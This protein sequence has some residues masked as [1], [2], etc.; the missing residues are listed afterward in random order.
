M[1]EELET[2]THELVVYDGSSRS[3]TSHLNLM[4]H[5]SF[6]PCVLATCVLCLRYDGFMLVALKDNNEMLINCAGYQVHAPGE[7]SVFCFFPMPEV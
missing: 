3:T 7:K 5:V 2:I 4:G 1:P 6:V